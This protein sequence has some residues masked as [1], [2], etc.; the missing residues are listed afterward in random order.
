[1]YIEVEE[2]YFD[3]EN[4]EVVISGYDVSE[5]NLMK[6]E[7]T[8]ETYQDPIEFRFSYADC[9]TVNDFH[10]NNK[11]TAY[12]RNKI[13][14]NCKSV[15]EHNPKSWQEICSLM[16]GTRIELNQNYRVIGA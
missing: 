15:M 9:K 13:K 11:P 1:M 7:R 3:R 12:L 6:M 2:M 4:K 8:R 16:I 14:F 10:F 5:L